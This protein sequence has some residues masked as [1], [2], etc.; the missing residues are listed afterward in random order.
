M[1][2]TM[3][4]KKGM[5]TMLR[6]C[7]ALCFAVA[8]SALPA[9]AQDD[10]ARRAWAV[11]FQLGTN[12]MPHSQPNGALVPSQRSSS[13]SSIG[14]L[15]KVHVE[16]YFGQG[17]HFSVKAGYEHEEVN[18]LEG[19]YSSDFDELMLGGRWYPAPGRWAIQP[20]AGID[21]L[22]NLNRDR[23]DFEMASTSNDYSYTATGHATMPRFSLG[24][25]VGA[26]IYLFSCIALQV[27]Y[28]YRWGIDARAGAHYAESSSRRTEYHHAQP[29]RHAL[30]IG[31]KV[32]FPFSF[33]RSDVN[34]L[35]DGLFD[36]KQE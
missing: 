2:P 19:D 15:T 27:E 34:S 11:D 30:A 29:H 31:V 17:S 24:P 16:R 22:W 14:L 25:V 23:G 36:I 8:A 4:H 21:L 13:T 1:T 18:M 12:L 6:L 35:L 10:G 3:H 9:S 7:V 26:D 5:G 33:S 28:G 32:T 20:Y